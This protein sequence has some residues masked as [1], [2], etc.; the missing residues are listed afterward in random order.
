MTWWHTTVRTLDGSTLVTSRP[1]AEAMADASGQTMGIALLA[2]C[3]LAAL[4]AGWAMLHRRLAEPLQR[5]ATAGEDLR[6]R[7]EMRPEVRTSLNAL[8]GGPSELRELAL[9]L[10]R[11][12]DETVRGQQQARSLLAAAGALGAS[13][14]S[15]PVLDGTLDQLQRLI[16]VERSVIIAYDVHG[17]TREVIASRGHSPEFQDD[18]RSDLHDPTVPSRRAVRERIP[19]QLGD[20]LSDLVSEKMRAR[21]ISSRLSQRAR[22]P[23]GR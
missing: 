8:S 7:G 3:L 22:D 10:E 12:E 13:L 15:A 14:E 11:I 17:P 18:L 23:I 1:E 20:T 5:L 16:G 21:S 4:A 19:V 9:A 6:V 2:A